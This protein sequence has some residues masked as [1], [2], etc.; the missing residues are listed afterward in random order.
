MAKSTML[1]TARLE[2]KTIHIVIVV[3]V[4]F[5]YPGLLFPVSLSSLIS[6]KAVRSTSP[7]FAMPYIN[8]ISV[9]MLIKSGII[10]T[11][12]FILI[13]VDE[14]IHL[15][16]NLTCIFPYSHLLGVLDKVFPEIRMSDID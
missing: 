12:P 10:D 7:H 15:K 14:S 1:T 13:F 2:K 4:R 11:L 9:Y 6:T 16:R 8:K 3:I 5:F